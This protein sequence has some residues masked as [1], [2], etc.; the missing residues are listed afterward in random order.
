MDSASLNIA[1]GQQSTRYMAAKQPMAGTRS[2][3]L[4]ID[5][6][7]DGSLKGPDQS[8]W[9]ALKQLDFHCL[10]MAI[11]PHQ[12]ESILN[13]WHRRS[14]DWQRLE[15]PGRQRSHAERS[16]PGLPYALIQAIRHSPLPDMSVFCALS[17]Q[18]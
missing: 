7:A 17:L 10:P 15:L 6:E 11:K 14:R 4:A 18:R 2:E 8:L 13:N 1:T 9:P 12:V 3:L 5:V 16:T